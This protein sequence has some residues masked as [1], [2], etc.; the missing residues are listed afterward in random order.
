MIYDHKVNTAVLLKCCL[1]WVFS[2]DYG[3]DLWQMTALPVSKWTLVCRL[4]LAPLVPNALILFKKEHPTACH[5]FLRCWWR[6][7]SSLQL[8][9]LSCAIS[10]FFW[11]PAPLL[12]QSCFLEIVYQKIA[13]EQLS[14][15]CSFLFSISSTPSPYLSFISSPLLDFFPLLCDGVVLCN[16]KIWS[17]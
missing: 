11:L 2:P 1:L 13:A 15:D 16:Q 4:F 10:S 17:L 3:R 7:S 9:F 6:S 8:S 14:F 12:S 5:A